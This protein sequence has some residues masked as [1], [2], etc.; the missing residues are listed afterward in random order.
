[1]STAHT[2]GGAAIGGG[3]QWSTRIVMPN[4][5][6][7]RRTTKGSSPR[8]LL[9]DSPAAELRALGNKTLITH[10]GRACDVLRIGDVSKLIVATAL[11]VGC[12]APRASEQLAP[13]APEWTTVQSAPSLAGISLGEA[14]ARIRAL[15]GAPD[16]ERLLRRGITGMIYIRPGLLAV[17]TDSTGALIL[18]IYNGEAAKLYGVGLGDSLRSVRAQ[19]VRPVIQSQPLCFGSGRNGQSASSPIR[20]ATSWAQSG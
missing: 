15:R 7:T 11:V 9:M 19:W 14:P 5:R 18:E 6:C 10:V 20:A 17:V 1:M 3:T 12:A 13:S 2:A 16:Q 4:E 8:S